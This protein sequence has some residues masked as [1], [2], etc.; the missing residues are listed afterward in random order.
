MLESAIELSTEE[1]AIAALVM[2]LAAYVRGLTGFAL[3][4]VLVAG[5]S[6]FMNPVEVVALALLSEV[7][8]SVIQA[9][10]VWSDIRWK[11]LGVLL[12]AAIIG[13]PVGIW[14]LTSTDPDTLRAATFVVLA[15]VS[16]GLLFNHA[17]PLPASIPIFF[18]I[19]VAAGVI[20][21]ATALSGLVIVL[22]MS[23]MEISPTAMR[24]TLVAYFFASNLA[25]VAFLATRGD[26]DESTLW[27]LLLALPLLAV[28]I[29]FGSSTFRSTQPEQFRRITLFLLI[30]ISAVGI[31]R[32]AT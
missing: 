17:T 16:V 18:A 12:A 28:G 23:F 3:S 2:L 24:S 11:H 19:G 14:I 10:S 27:R 5:L 25:V 26:I 8:A 22:G 29:A 9:R 20:N 13:N 7:A 15:I 31:L 1:A 30:A 32:I 6:F 4:A 21:G